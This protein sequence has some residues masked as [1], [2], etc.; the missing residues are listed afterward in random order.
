MP[1]RA[2][3]E[4]S[5]RI[6]FGIWAALSR[7]TAT[8]CATVWRCDRP[9]SSGFHWAFRREC[10]FTAH[11][12]GV[13]LS[14]FDFLGVL[15]VLDGFLHCLLDHLLHRVLDILVVEHVFAGLGHRFSH[16]LLHT[17]R[18]WIQFLCE[19]LNCLLCFLS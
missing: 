17:D 13:T 8:T 2:V 15:S 11:E 6:S 5:G 18:E 7:V 3:S 9:H 4:R 19:D 16:G 14:F 12:L 1:P 10:G